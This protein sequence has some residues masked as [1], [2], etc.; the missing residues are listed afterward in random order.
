MIKR[1]NPDTRVRQKRAPAEP[2]VHVVEALGKHFAYDSNSMAAFEVDP[3]T[4]DLVRE[5]DYGELGSD[6]G[7]AWR[8]HFNLLSKPKVRHLVLEATHAC[9]LACRYCF[10]RNYYDD[11]SGHMSFETAYH[12]I[13]AL[14]LASPTSLNVGFF[15]GEALL[16]FKLIEQVVTYVEELV[17]EVYVPCKFSMTTNATLMTAEIAQFLDSHAFSLIVSLDGDEETHNHMRPTCRQGFNSHAMTM[18]GLQ[19]LKGLPIARRLTLRSTFTGLSAQLVERLEYLNNLIEQGIGSHASVE[20]CSLNESACINLPDGHPLSITTEKAQALN[21]EYAEAA[22]WLVDRVRNG[23]PARFHH[24]YKMVERLLWG[25]VSP[26]ECGAGMGYAAVGPDGT[27]YACHREGA[28]AIGSLDAGIDEASRSKWADNRWC[29]RERCPECWLRHVCGGGCRLDSLDRYGDIRCPD[30]AACVF[31]SHW[32]KYAMWIMS[33]LTLD[34]LKAYA[35][36]PRGRRKQSEPRRPDRCPKC[37]RK[38]GRP[39]AQPAEEADP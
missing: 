3:S 16:N 26:T 39:T 31:K 20:P 2:D 37:G 34:Q 32:I 25:I 29:Q 6:F 27:I 21:S 8:P 23:R 38:P 4:A 9:N 28:S 11:Q 13:N 22:Q 17:S 10:V 30:E 1:L 33:E 5:G 19:H 35:P 15:G 14:L 24:F 18:A 7:V 12:A 36:C